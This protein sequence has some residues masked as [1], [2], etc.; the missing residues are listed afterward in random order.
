MRREVGLSSSLAHAQAHTRMQA[1]VFTQVYVVQSLVLWMRVAIAVSQ[2][3]AV[4]SLK[5]VP[6]ALVRAGSA[7]E[8]WTVTMDGRLN[9]I[10]V[11][12]PTHHLHDVALGHLKYNSEARYI[13]CMFLHII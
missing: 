7:S 3:C 11:T 4:S 12:N 9:R 5:T 1:S 8:N 10:D 6:R 2:P 13:F